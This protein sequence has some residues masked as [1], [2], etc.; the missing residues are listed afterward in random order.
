MPASE[1]QH[2]INKKTVI[3]Y[4][5]ALK[6][7][8]CTSNKFKIVMLSAEEAGKTSTVYFLLVK[9]FHSKQP[10]TVGAA[11]NSCTVDCTYATDWKQNELY[12]QLDQLP[13]QFN[14]ESTMETE[15][16]HENQETFS[17]EDSQA[18]NV[19]DELVGIKFKRFLPMKKF[20]MVI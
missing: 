1:K 18:K 12:Y 6:R 14:S 17:Q 11:L 20:I 10:S 5:N 19:P 3:A 13:K 8:K 4:Q 16:I 2:S 9:E 7:G 15:A